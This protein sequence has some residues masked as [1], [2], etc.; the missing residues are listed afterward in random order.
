MHSLPA[1]LRRYLYLTYG[2][3]LAILIVSFFFVPQSELNYSLFIAFVLISVIIEFNL[4]VYQNIHAHNINTAILTAAAFIFPPSIVTIIALTGPAL[5]GIF[6]KKPAYKTLFNTAYQVIEF[7][8][9]SLII[10]ALSPKLTTEEG[11][12]TPLQV[13]LAFVVY[14]ALSTG[15]I[16]ILFTLA[17]RQKITTAWRETLKVFNIFDLA[18]LPYGLILAQLWFE[19]WAYFVVGLI[20]LIALHYSF[21][22]HANLLKEKESTAQLVYQQR[23]V[24]E[25][26]TVLLSSQDVHKQ[27]DTLLQHLMEVFPILQASVL[28]WGE[29]DEPDEVVVRG[30]AKLTL[31]IADW[32]DKLRHICTYRRIVH[33]DQEYITR[34]TEGR[35]VLLVPLVTPDDLV[36][37]LVLLSAAHFAWDDP[38]TRLLETFA[39]QAGIAIYEARL[40]TR[41]KS[42]QVRVVQSERLAAIGTL[43]AGVAHE[44]NN[45]L[46]GI[47][48]IAQ[49]ALITNTPEEQRTALDTVAQAAQQGGSITRGLMTFARRLEPKRELADVHTAIEPVLL[50]LQA[51]FRRANIVV[52][53][54]LKV[55][56]PLECDIGMLSQ[57]MLNLMTNAIDAMY[58]DGGTLTIDL[59]EE[60]QCI[61]L[62]VSDT[63]SGIPAHI[64]DKIFE[65][66]VSTKTNSNN[67]L[68]G[69]TGLGLAISYGVITEHG[70]TITVHDCEGG[71]TKMMIRLPIDPNCI[72]PPKVEEVPKGPLHMIV[73]D[74]E[75]LIAKALHGMLTRDGHI[76]HWFTE[77]REALEA[78]NREPVDL[79]FADLTMPEMDGLTLL[80]HAKQQV[81]WVTPVVITG[82][83][84][85]RQL[86]QVRAAGIAAVI[87]KP[88]SLDDI[89]AVVRNIQA[90]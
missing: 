71:G 75:P 44:F 17:N 15:L 16:G 30:Q 69:G 90:A 88:F 6:H 82:H 78:I 54:N 20:P 14:L 23:Q 45:L 83:T 7:G 18:L 63:G 60:E 50:M 47:S 64:R 19:N 37:C 80:S 5:F 70:G 65:P 25:A 42:S 74:D 36:G 28:I 8:T 86:E 11:A 66:F 22:V 3:A 4:V 58:P 89:R 62:A 2:C 76:A 12:V 13:V 51:E 53:R 46:A 77:P 55:V 24:H 26:T 9:V 73:V 34:V 68:H 48:G 21:A 56:P 85:P 29:H 39:A 87:E 38:A 52:V 67:K 31:P 1:A 10:H 35:P 79:I 33:L 81:P 72:T 49:L 32:S 27:L 41:L 59:Y 40:I 57:V 43:A 61:V 84:D